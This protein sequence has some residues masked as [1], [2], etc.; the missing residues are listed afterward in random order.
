MQLMTRLRKRAKV[1]MG[2]ALALL[3]LASPSAVW[4]QEPSEDYKFL[5][6][7]NV[8]GVSVSADGSCIAAG[9]RDNKVYLFSREGKL[10]WS[11]DTGHYILGVSV[12][13]DGSY[14]VAGSTDNK[15][16][17]FSR[18]GKLHLKRW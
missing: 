12:S 13:G 15:V 11:Y 10:L 2:L 17:F 8:Y 7:Y 5:W 16:Y 14:I 3:L 18:E 9:S 6:S 4:A 1:C